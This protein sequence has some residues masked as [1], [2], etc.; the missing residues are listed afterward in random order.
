[1]KTGLLCRF[2]HCCHWCLFSQ[3]M[4]PY[5]TLYKLQSRCCPQKHH[6]LKD[7]AFYY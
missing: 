1:M 7:F 5:I 4:I 6:L 3:Q 2:N